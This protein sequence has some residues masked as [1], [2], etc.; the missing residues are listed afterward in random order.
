MLRGAVAV[1]MDRIAAQD[2]AQRVADD[3][4]AKLV[5]CSAALAG[6]AGDRPHLELENLG[7]SLA[8]LSAAPYTPQVLDRDDTAQI[9]FTSGTTAEPRGV[10]LTHGNLL[11]SVDPIEQEMPKYH[12]YERLFHPIRFLE[13][14]PLSHVF[15][16]FMGMF[17]PPLIGGTVLFQESFKPSDVIT[18][19]KRERI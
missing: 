3:V 10:V 18:T 9:V 17:I 5:V 7:G 15:G 2:F 12:K 1:P 13:M 8:H 4:E 16:Q 14:L 19:I 6:L 11:A